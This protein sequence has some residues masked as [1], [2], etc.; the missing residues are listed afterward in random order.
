MQTIKKVNSDTV[1]GAQP[2]DLFNQPPVHSGAT[3]E[4]K[5]DKDRL[6]GQLLKIVTCMKDAAWRT[7]SEI[8]TITLAPASSISAQLRHLR[9]PAFG[10]HTVNKRPRG[11]RSKGLF[12]Y[13]LILNTNKVLC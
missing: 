4:A 5:H 6:T 2:F 12:E 11:D 7:L 3:Y 10:S 9:K 1:N 13:Q 8:E